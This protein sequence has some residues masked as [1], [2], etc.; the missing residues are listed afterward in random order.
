MKVQEWCKEKIPQVGRKTT[1]QALTLLKCADA[2]FEA[3]KNLQDHM[4]KIE[5]GNADGNLFYQW[6][7]E[8]NR[9]SMELY[10]KAEAYEQAKK[11]C[12]LE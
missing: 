2:F 4:G 6:D 3:D 11:D 7:A 8:Y 12:G 1:V 10:K 9:L 5:E